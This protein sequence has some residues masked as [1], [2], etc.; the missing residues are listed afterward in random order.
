MPTRH[1]IFQALFTW[2]QE[3]TT[4][5]IKRLF[6]VE[7][8]H[9]RVQRQLSFMWRESCRLLT[10]GRIENG[11]KCCQMECSRP[12]LLK[13]CAQIWKEY[14]HWTTCVNHAWG[15]QTC[16][17]MWKDSSENKTAPS[18]GYYIRT[19]EDRVTTI[20]DCSLCDPRCTCCSSTDVDL[21]KATD[22]FRFLP[23]IA[24]IILR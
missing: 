18:L 16:Q 7:G 1:D 23:H 8:D 17:F 14:P 2:H 13:H 15:W 11:V 12:T 9:L 19:L 21:W 22:F 5:A 24:K 20:N 3:R 10:N 4:S 6:R